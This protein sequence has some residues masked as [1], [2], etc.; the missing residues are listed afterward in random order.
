[1]VDHRELRRDDELLGVPFDA[2][3]TANAIRL[4]LNVSCNA[5][6][7]RAGSSEQSIPSIDIP[8]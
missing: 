6:D 7:P 3:Y 5:P 2:Y 8:H 4:L 1:M